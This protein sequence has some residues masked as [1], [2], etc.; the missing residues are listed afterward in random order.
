MARLAFLVMFIVLSIPSGKV[1]AEAM[2]INKIFDAIQ[3]TVSG[4]RAR[5]YVMRLWIHEKWTTLPGW[6]RAVK[7]ARDIMRE[8]GFDEVEIGS[9]PA[10]GKTKSGA[11]TNPLGWDV[12]QATLE[13]IEPSNVP[14]D[15]RYLCNYLDNP[16]CLNAWS[17]PTP[18]GGIETEI[19]L[20]EG[21]DPSTLEKLNA[22][23]KIVLTSAGTRG[24]KRFLDRNGILGFVGDQIEALNVDFVNA[25]QWLNG[26]SDLPGG[27]WFTSYD[28]KNNFG[29]SIS[30]KKA[31]YLRNLLRAGTKVRVRATIDSRY[32]ADDTLDYVTGLVKGS[33]PEGE[34]VLITGH[35]NEWGA[36]DNSAGCSAIMEAV[37]TINDLVKAGKLPRPKRSIRV[38]LGAEMYGSL[39]WVEKNLG[40]LNSKTVAALCCDTATPNMDEVTTLISVYM[41]PNCCPTFTDA[42][43]PE[44]VKQYLARYSPNR[45]FTV[46]P[47]S[48]GT[49]TYF[50]EPMIGVPTNWIYLSAG[51]HLHHNSMDTIDKIDPRTIREL[52]FVNA[53]WLYF[54][55][56]AGY[57]DAPW[58]NRLAFNRGVQVIRDAADGAVAK[59]LAADGAS[60]GA[61]LAD[62]L[63]R[64]DYYSGLQRKAL[65][66]TGRIVEAA[67]KNDFTADLAP[68]DTSLGEI[69]QSMAKRLR[70]I[71]ENRA[72]TAG[73][74]LA[75]AASQET[76]WDREAATLIPKR[77]HFGTLFLEEVPVSEWKEITS[78]PHWW[79]ET[80]WASASF[81]WVDG[82]RSLKE[83]K[84]LCELEAG[85]PVAG[86]DLINY[87]R[88]LEKF[89][90]VE[91][92]QP[93][94][95]PSK[96]GAKKK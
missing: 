9:T 22:R 80:N 49:D 45:T 48:M 89:K 57:D 67:R 15:I 75:A 68:Y 6:K 53:A 16:T 40:L 86:F 52:S 42:V 24:M 69:G 10:D 30:Q 47:F 29:F 14:D 79:G 82:K 61:V 25:N 32:F 41:N 95:E 33:G 31:N 92:V 90:Y 17:A 38:L 20:M 11:W 34:E 2:S 19:V 81:W 71:A 64:I 72:K 56:N 59:V 36:S 77:F 63:E 18:P 91:F 66:S 37:G 13:V 26:W 8:R 73:I 3:S 88:F 23:G 35:M 46:E 7:E 74:K 39:P 5:D 4:N 55:A 94:A 43:L 96:K 54:I 44:I 62:G 51:A 87:Y 78:S 93:P 12:K 50:C 27:W 58:I 21:S 76:A 85:V 28:S 1:S 60:L 65:A 84:R 70:T 83:I